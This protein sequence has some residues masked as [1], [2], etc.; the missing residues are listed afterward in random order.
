[1]AETRVLLWVVLLADRKAAEM[2]GC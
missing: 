1:M 2:A